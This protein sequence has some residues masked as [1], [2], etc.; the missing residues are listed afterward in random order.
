M[1]KMYLKIFNFKKTQPFKNVVYFWLGRH[2][3]WEE[4]S[5]DL[6]GTFFKKMANAG[7]LVC[8]TSKN[9]KNAPAFSFC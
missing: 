8:L 2:G 3:Q 6:S 5:L 7:R 1:F 4:Y 9:D